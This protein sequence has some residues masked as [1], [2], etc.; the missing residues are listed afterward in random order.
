MRSGDLLFN[1]VCPSSRT[2]SHLHCPMLTP[3]SLSCTLPS[4]HVLRTHSLATTFANPNARLHILLCTRA[5]QFSRPLQLLVEPLH[6]NSPPH[7]CG[8]HALT[9]T[10][11]ATCTFPPFKHACPTST[12]SPPLPAVSPAHP[13]Y[14]LPLM[15]GEERA[16]A[17]ASGHHAVCTR[18]PP[19]NHPPTT[20]KCVF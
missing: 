16:G 1:V 13:H 2:R 6:H 9:H 7:R 20:R 5:T 3:S 17:M 12:Q 19:P 8:M 15:L 11:S 18:P 10:T 4:Y 14:S